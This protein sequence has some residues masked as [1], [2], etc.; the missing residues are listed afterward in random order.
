MEAESI[1]LD[2]MVYIEKDEI[3]KNTYSPLR[4]KYPNQRIH[5]SYGD[6]LEYTVAHS[7]NN[8]CDWLIR[9][10]GGMDKVDTYIKSLGI[11]DL[12]FTE[13]ENQMHLDIMKCYNNWNTP[14]SIARL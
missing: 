9:F 14:L 6:I 7:D 4:N 10:V 5:I 13:T 12:N 3:L 11:K 1:P 8:T 2:R